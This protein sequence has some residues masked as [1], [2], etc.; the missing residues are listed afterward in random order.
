MFQNQKYYLQQLLLNY[1]RPLHLTCVYSY[2]TENNDLHSVATYS[3]ILVFKFKKKQIPTL[4]FTNTKYMCVINKYFDKLVSNTV[5]R[6]LLHTETTISFLG[7]K[8][9]KS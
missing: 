7:I 4:I 8:I 2:T 5:S 3:E 9:K 1:T 6:N